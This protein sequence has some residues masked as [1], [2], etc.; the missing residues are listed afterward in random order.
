MGYGFAAFLKEVFINFYFDLFSFLVFIMS[1]ISLF[2]I[3]SSSGDLLLR[4]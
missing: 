4:L 3:F 1:S 2:V